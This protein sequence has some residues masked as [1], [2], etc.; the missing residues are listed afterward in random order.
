MGKIPEQFVCDI[1]GCENIVPLTS[2]G[3]RD[4]IQAHFARL[5]QETED[6][7]KT[8]DEPVLDS[9]ELDLCDEHL[10]IYIER[11]P[12]K[13]RNNGRRGIIFTMEDES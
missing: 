2:T 9:A 12:I 10:S 11:L 7:L 8:L 6:R 13:G 1:K 4:Y 5:T 3:K